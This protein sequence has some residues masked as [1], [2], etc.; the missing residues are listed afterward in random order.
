MHGFRCRVVERRP[1]AI[2]EASTRHS[3]FLASEV[4]RLRVSS[5]LS[6]LPHEEICKVRWLFYRGDDNYGLG[7]VLYDVA[8]AAALALVLNRTLV[9]GVNAQDRKFG[10]LLRWPGVL[11]V[12]DV[13]DWRR[14]AKCS[15]GLLLS[16]RRA[17]F[18]PTKC[19]TARSWRREKSG[20]VRCFRKLLGVN[21]LKEPSPVI[22][23][24]K[25]QFNPTK[26]CRSLTP[27][28]L[29]CC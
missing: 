23:L 29:L 15:S 1:E 25:V 10:A 18:N 21:W 28:P 14:V 26:A 24:T 22:E 20:Q 9:Y 16:Q 3:R 8:A 6:A 11:T 5:D 7:N 2:T 17:L 27:P 4:T 12:A 19:T 13:D